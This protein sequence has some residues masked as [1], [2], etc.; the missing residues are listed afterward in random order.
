LAILPASS[1]RQK[2][3]LRLH[4]ASEKACLPLDLAG[5]DRRSLAANSD[6]IRVPGNLAPGLLPFFNNGPVFG[7]P[8][9]VTGDIWN[10]T[11]LTGDWGGARTDLA[12]HGVFIDVYS[13]SDHQNVTSGTKSRRDFCAEHAGFAQYRHRP[14][15][16]YRLAFPDP[17]RANDVLPAQ[18]F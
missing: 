8:G 14:R 6:E 15:T 4:L 3:S 17:I 18:F 7:I 9:T 11:Q 10:R 1:A 16:V 12:R 13:T 5:I 2:R